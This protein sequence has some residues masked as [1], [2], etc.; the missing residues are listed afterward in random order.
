MRNRK[1]VKSKET[2]VAGTRGFK[3]YRKK[4]PVI[5][6]F[7]LIILFLLLS[8]SITLFLI[9]Q[10]VSGEAKERIEKGAIQ[11]IIFSE[12]PVYFDNGEDIIGVF[13]DKTHRKYIEYQDVPS[14]FIKAIVA[15]EDQ[16]FFHH[17]GF[18]LKGI[19]RALVT[20]LRAGKVVQG[21]STITQ[22]TAKNIFK[23]EKR[24]YRAKLKELMQALLLEQ[25][26]TKEEILEMYV[27]QFFVTGFGSGL[28]IAARYFFDKDAQDLDLGECAFV[29]GSVKGPYL[30]NPFTKKTQAEKSQALHLA[31]ARKNYVLRKMMNLHFITDEIYRKEVQREVPFQEG[32][33]TYRLNVILDY[34]RDQLESEFFRSIL[35]DQGV[36]NIATSGIKIFTS[37]NKEIQEQALASM[38]T[39][40]PV[41]DLHISGYPRNLLQQRYEKYI[42]DLRGKPG[43][44]LPILC[45]ITHVDRNPE[46]P[47]LVVAWKNGGGIIDYEGFRAVGEAWLKSRIGVWAVFGAA[48]VNDFFD[49]FRVG[50][51]IPVQ[52][53]A[54]GDSENGARLRLTHLPELEGGIVVLQEGKI[55]AM[56][57]GFWDRFFNRSAHAKRQLG[58]IFKTYVFTAALQLKWSCLDAIMN[59]R[60]FYTF[61]TTHYDPRPDHEPKADPVSMAW[62]GA[63]SENLAAVWLLYH[64]TDRLNQDEFRQVVEKL[65]LNRGKAETYQEYVQRI[66]DR[67]GVVVDKEAIMEAAFEAARKEIE[68][69]LIFDGKEKVLT[70]L[71]RLHY[72]IDGKG[73]DPKEPRTW[74]IYRFSFQGLQSLNFE[75]KEQYGAIRMALRPGST[76]IRSP[77]DKRLDQLAHKFYLFLQGPDA[78][79]IAYMSTPPPEKSKADFIPMAP[80]WLEDRLEE[81][82]VEDVWIEGVLSSGLVDLLQSRMK[83]HYERL[84]KHKRYEPEILFKIRDFITLV[85]LTYVVELCRE[86]GIS[87][88]LDPVLSFPLGANAISIMEAALTYHVLMTGNRY[89]SGQGR[90][91]GMVPAI[92]KILDREG[93][94]IW[95]YIPDPVPVLSKEISGSVSEILRLVMTEGTGKKA[96]EAIKVIKTIGEESIQIPIPTFGKTG[97]ANRFTNSSFIGFIPGKGDGSSFDMER[98]Y[99]IASYVG[100]DDNRPM[101]G[102]HVAIYGASGALPLWIDTANAIVNLKEYSEDL[103]AAELVFEMDPSP[104]IPGNSFR[105]VPVDKH[106][107]LPL[108]KTDS[109]PSPMIYALSG[110]NGE[111]GNA[112]RLFQPISSGLYGQEN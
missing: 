69:D 60:D 62:A 97:T 27:N 98:G 70:N 96:K 22:Q 44:N 80:E 50:D 52:W 43:W 104:H 49:S 47:A 53:E 37:V 14:L 109:G 79:E 61:E 101:K 95:E 5:K 108:E 41:L 21:G 15:S 112:R 34:I 67:M 17:S 28:E 54:N 90:D 48:H 56:V 89:P 24:S 107:G 9:Y 38:R 29:A 20:N 93:E 33:V 111:I 81:S 74:D 25:R 31:K 86:M 3:I 18:D 6:V 2:V 110:T 92:M 68:P 35:S 39:H 77:G 1:S 51:L 46:R 83:V 84:I 16:N 100:Y 106:S 85:N 75:L 72:T 11:S 23:R 42:G 55:K 57:G 12:S 32:T 45:R 103:V 73:L 19:L 7:F 13:F 78:Q 91:P 58:S 30:Y 65:S 40:L 59:G 99:V 26:Y 4:G 63:K 64:L 82:R 8:G 88:K 76:P 36:N 87:T 94:I 10:Q 71:R 105:P 102:E 66:R